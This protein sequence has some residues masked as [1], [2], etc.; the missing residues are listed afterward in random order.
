MWHSIYDNFVIILICIAYYNISRKGG[1]TLDKSQK[2]IT[3]D[4]V[5]ERIKEHIR[6][7]LAT[8]IAKALPARLLKKFAVRIR[9]HKNYRAEYVLLFSA[10]FFYIID[11]IFDILILLFGLS[12]I[13]ISMSP[14][15]SAGLR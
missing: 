15:F 7:V 4:E 2:V 6:D 3:I 12:G 8:A 5:D 14:F 13:V 11:F 1:G 9:I 10:L